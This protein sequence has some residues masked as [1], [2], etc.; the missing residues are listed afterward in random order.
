MGVI[1]FEKEAAGLM[2]HFPCVV[3]R[4]ICDY[5]DSHLNK[6]W[7]RYAAMT[8]AAYA[9]DLLNR[10]SSQG[11]AVAD[12]ASRILAEGEVRNGIQGIRDIFGGP[13]L[14]RD[15]PPPPGR[16]DHRLP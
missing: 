6:D 4:G 12:A 13:S 11:V 8:A 2:N 9:K 10:V 14:E 5:S 15:R 3:I 1:C 16:G 7:Q